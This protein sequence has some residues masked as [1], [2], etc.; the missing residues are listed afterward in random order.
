MM[1]ASL[2][3]L[4]MSAFTKRHPV[5]MR[6]QMS[7]SVILTVTDDWIIALWLVMETST[8]GETAA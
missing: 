1:A 6:K 7:A 2:R 3:A 5:D 4:E 8:A